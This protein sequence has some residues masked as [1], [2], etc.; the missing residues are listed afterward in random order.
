M[1]KERPTAGKQHQL[2]IRWLIQDAMYGLEQTISHYQM[3]WS[4]DKQQIII[5]IE[6]HTSLMLPLREAE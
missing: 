5:Y 1:C 6:V 2:H 4:V 3:V